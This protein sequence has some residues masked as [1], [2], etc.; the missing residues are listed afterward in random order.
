MKVEYNI[1]EWYP[2]YTITPT[3]IDEGYWIVELPIELLHEYNDA[4]AAF[5]KIQNKLGEILDNDVIL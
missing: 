3:D 1:E 4:L 5:S 2:I